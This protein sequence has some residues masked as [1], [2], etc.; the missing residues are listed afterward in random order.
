[1]I[2]SAIPDPDLR[3]LPYF[4]VYSGRALCN[5]MLICFIKNPFNIVQGSIFV[6]PV[7]LCG[8]AEL[9]EDAPKC[10]NMFSVKYRLS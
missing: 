8:Q 3:L 4:S 7:R 1:M 6:Q 5:F 10:T 2:A 9:T